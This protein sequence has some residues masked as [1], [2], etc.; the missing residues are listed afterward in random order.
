M[1]DYTNQSWVSAEI[2]RLRAELQDARGHY[3]RVCAE[4]DRLQRFI[5]SRPAITAALPE[6]YAR[7]SRRIYDSE[8]V[9]MGEVN[10]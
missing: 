3:E 6:S 1:A 2:E 9:Q 4:R 5:D 10:G 8:I 7:W